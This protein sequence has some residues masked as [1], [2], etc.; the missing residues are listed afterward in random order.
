[1]AAGCSWG[2][3]E[4]LKLPRRQVWDGIRRFP[5]CPMTYNK[6]WWAMIASQPQSNLTLYWL[7]ASPPWRNDHA[8]T[9]HT[10]P[11]RVHCPSVVTS[12]AWT[13]KTMTQ[14]WTCQL[15]RPEKTCLAWLYLLKPSPQLQ[16]SRKGSISNKWAW[17]TKNG[18]SLQHKASQHSFSN[19]C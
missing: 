19:Q 12:T 18:L 3:Q 9:P 13:S 7:N 15:T 2:V 17:G 1:M 11:S 10:R 16:S 6:H 4:G 14:K 5:S 8:G